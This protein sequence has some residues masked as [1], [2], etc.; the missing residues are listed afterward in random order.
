[1]E[2]KVNE[3]KELELSFEFDQNKVLS[4]ITVT[5]KSNHFNPDDFINFL[6]SPK[7]KKL[8]NFS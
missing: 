3:L 7:V 1:M 5:D 6:N 2:L 4:K 8:I